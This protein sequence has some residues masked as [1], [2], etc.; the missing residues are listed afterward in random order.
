[1]TRYTYSTCLSFGTDGEPDY[2]E[3]DTT[4][5]YTVIPGEPETGPTY[6]CGGT[7]ASDPQ[8][9]D[10]RVEKIDGKPVV[11]GDAIT[12]DAILSEFEC[13]HHDADLLAEAASDRDH[14]ADLR[15]E[16]IRED[17]GATTT[18]IESIGGER[19]Q[20]LSFQIKVF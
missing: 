15:A 4:I 18:C 20:R 5:S 6:D 14:A 13:G 16:Q 2:C 12:R 17:R 1:M 3:I 10:I 7:P 9:D 19:H 8:I 11:T